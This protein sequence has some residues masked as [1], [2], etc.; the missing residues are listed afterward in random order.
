MQLTAFT[1]IDFRSWL[2]TH[3]KESKIAVIVHKKHMGKPSPAHRKMVYRW[4]LRGKRKETR[5][6]RIKLVVNQA[7]LNNRAVFTT[8]EKING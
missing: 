1:R 8:Q 7:E 6:K 2:A 4:I 3:K 5:E